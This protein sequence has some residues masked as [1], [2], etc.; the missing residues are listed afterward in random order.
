[1]FDTTGCTGHQLAARLVANEAELRQRECEVLVLAAGWADLHDLDTTAPGYEP[2]VERGVAYG[3]E[4]CPD[5]SEYAVHELGALRGTS[6]GTAEQLIADA[7]DLRHRHPRLWSR[8]RA[9]EVRAWQAVHV[10][11][12]CHPLSQQAAGLVDLAVTGYLGQLPWARF[13]RILQAAI[14]QADR[15][16]AATQAEKARQAR[17]VWAYSGEDGLRTLVAKAASGD[18]TVLMA[19]VNRLADVL[20]V[21]GDTDPADHRRAK[22]LGLLAQPARALQLLI[23]HQHDQDA[24]DAGPDG[25]EPGDP[26]EEHRSLD[27]KAPDA[28]AGPDGLARAAALRPQVVLHFHLSDVTVAAGHGVVRPEHD[29]PTSLQQL[30]DWLRESGCAVSVRPVLDPAAVAAVD[31]YETPARMREALFT[32]HPAEVFPFGAATR[33]LDCDHSTPYVR[34]DRGGPPGQTGMHSLGPLAR[35]H[36]RAVT[37]GLWRRRQPEPGRYVFRTPHGYVFVVT[38][39][40]SISLGCD[41]FAADVWRRAKQSPARAQTSRAAAA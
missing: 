4:G 8:V 39:Q 33:G 35:S 25:G 3:G 1:M 22:A 13:G 34:P 14:V 20:A 27:L 19:T 24:G 10:A 9:G 36:H 31:A 32:R 17:G 11:R 2:L 5:V 26:D 28:L 6:S 37:H 38:N 21:E 30:R 16:H 18:V 12:A 7:L 15:A 23:D 40:G 29:E 41:A